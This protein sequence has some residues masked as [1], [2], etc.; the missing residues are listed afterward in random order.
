MPA[1]SSKD[2]IPSVQEYVSDIIRQIANTRGFKNRMLVTS[3]E[4]EIDAHGKTETIEAK[5]KVES[6][7]VY[8]VL[9]SSGG[10]VKVDMA[11]KSRVEPENND[12]MKDLKKIK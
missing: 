4:Q 1:K 10:G 7:R 9:I 5:F 2:R 8:K 3:F 11:I 12:F 6:G